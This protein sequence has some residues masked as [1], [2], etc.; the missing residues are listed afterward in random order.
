MVQHCNDSQLYLSLRTIQAIAFLHQFL[1]KHETL[2]VL[3][4]LLTVRNDIS[5]HEHM[6]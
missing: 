1:R 3:Q 5:Q 2:G 4:H 6:W